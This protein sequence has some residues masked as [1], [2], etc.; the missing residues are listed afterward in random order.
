MT[1]STGRPATCSVLTSAAPRIDL[2]HRLHLTG[3]PQQRVEIVAENLDADVA[4][5]ARDQFV[6]AHLDRLREFVGAAR[7]VLDGPLDLLDEVGL[8]SSPDPAIPLRGFSM[9]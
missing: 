1:V 6:E 5:D 7:H 8:G 9:T 3:Q 2:Q 4:A